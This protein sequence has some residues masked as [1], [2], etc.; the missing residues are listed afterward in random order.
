MTHAAA[1][2]APSSPTP[3]R[4]PLI[5]FILWSLAVLAYPA[6]FLV[7][8]VGDAGGDRLR[9]AGLAIPTLLE[10]GVLRLPMVLAS[11]VLWAAAIGGGMALLRWAGFAALSV[12]ERAVFGGALGMGVFSIGT[13]LAGT[14]GGEPQWLF[15]VLVRALVV[16]FGALGARE[17]FAAARAGLRALDAWRRTTSGAGILI[18]ALAAAIVLLALTRANVPVFADYDSLEYHLAAPAAWW[19]EGRVTFIQ[20]VMYT[21]FPQNTEMLLLLAMN[22]L[23]GPGAGAVVGLQAL[24]GFVVLAAAGVAA[25]GRRLGSPAAG[26]AGAALLL[27]TPMLAELATLN[28]YVTEL[29]LAAYGFLALFAFILWRRAEAPRERWRYAALCGVMAG[30]AVGCKYPAVLFVLVPLE[31]FILGCGV[32]WPSRL[33]ASVGSAALVGVVA[34][35]VASPWLIRNA[36][37]TGN[38]TYPLLYDVFGGSN[39]SPEQEAKFASAHRSSDTRLIGLAHRFWRFALWRDQPAQGALPPAA[40]VLLLFALVPIALADRRSTGL[41]LCAGAVFL[42]LAAAERFWPER[43]EALEVA[44]SVGLSAFVLALVTSPAFLVLQGDALFLG[45]AGVLWLL[46]WYVLTHRLDRFLDPVSPAMAL[47]GGLGVAALVGAGGS[48]RLHERLARGLVAAGLAYALATTLLV[49][50]PVL[51]L[52]L[53]ESEGAFLRKVNEGSTYSHE[54]IEAINKLPEDATVLF[55]GESRTFYC[56]RRALA[57]TVFDRH[58]IDRILA[59]PHVAQ[60]PSAV[61]GDSSAPARRVRD[62][63]RALGVTHVYVAWPE[64]SRLASTYTYRFEGTAREGLPREVYVAL[65]T[66]M[67]RDGHLQPIGVFGT[68]REGRPRPEFVLYQLR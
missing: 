31:L 33:K 28:S 51:L 35:A 45:L 7:G 58:P 4:L 34:V 40:P 16:A 39:W 15:S 56:R 29:P 44:C 62:G 9:A 1:E 20:D 37:N 14:V 61:A 12:G 19:R 5:P 32:A 24:V 30:L 25:C 46:P 23:G 36:I 52:G 54:A 63:L 13:F 17:L 27:G 11:G 60:P 59:A 3:P 18:V 50:G 65:I 53:G 57:A 49:H 21:N 64:V 26:A 10:Q 47:L 42:G 43:P 67:M 6:C 55:V 68:D 41:V 66:A 22:C 8:L 48:S 2:P 38:P